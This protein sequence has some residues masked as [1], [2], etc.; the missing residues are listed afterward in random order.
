MIQPYA[1][2]KGGSF[3]RTVKDLKAFQRVTLKPGESKQVSFSLPASCL[4]FVRN[5]KKMLKTA[6]EYS[7]AI[8]LFS[9]V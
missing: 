1:Q 4:A 8:F 3:I 6:Y 9:T 2:D 5:R 7:Q